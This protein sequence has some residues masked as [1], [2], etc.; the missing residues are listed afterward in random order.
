MSTADIA[1]GDRE[2][3]LDIA[4]VPESSPQVGAA[5]TLVWREEWLALPRSMVPAVVRPEAGIVTAGADALAYLA[6]T[7]VGRVHPSAFRIVSTNSF[8]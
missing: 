7:A 8:S 4:G 3:V 2:R 1:T 5:R 6:G